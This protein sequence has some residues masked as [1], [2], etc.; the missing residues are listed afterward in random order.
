M[1]I[2]FP[3]GTSVISTVWSIRYFYNVLV[4]TERIASCLAIL[5]TGSFPS[6]NLNTK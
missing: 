2:Y 1:N 5:G 6:G 3:N 4:K